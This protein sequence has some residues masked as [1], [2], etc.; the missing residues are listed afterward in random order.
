M[1]LRPVRLGERHEG[2]HVGFGLVHHSCQLRDALAELIGDLSPGLRCSGMIGLQEHRS[3]GGCHHLM[4]G[5][6][7]IGQSIAH[8]VNTTPLPRR[9]EHLSDGSLQAFVR[10]R[11]DEPDALQPALLQA[12][13]E[14]EPEDGRL[15]RAETEP[16]DLA[17][18][19]SVHARGDYGRHRH[20]TPVLA[21]FQVSRV[22]P[23]IRPISLDRPLQKGVHPDIDA[24]AQLRHLAFRDPAHPHR[25]HEVVHLAGRHAL[26]PRLLDHRHQSLLGG[27]TR[28]QKAGEVRALPQLRDLQIERPQPR[29]EGA[30][31]I[32]VTLRR[33]LLVA[34]VAA[35]TDLALDV[36]GHQPP[37]HLLG[38]LLHEIAPAAL[39]QSV[40]KWHRVVGHRALRFVSRVAT[41]PYR[42]AR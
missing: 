22:E 7:H 6:R 21:H 41:R 34:F 25:L 36:V 8:E 37:Q 42:G 26:D 23:Q 33:A 4:L 9:S 39:Q 3:N 19:V 28:L 12:A 31:A 5:L 14:P 1:E 32:P 29:I 2:D 16:E 18:A 11:D 10:V 27:A 20:D 24:L 15:R 13:Q 35:R 38:Q 30:V 40:E 17:P